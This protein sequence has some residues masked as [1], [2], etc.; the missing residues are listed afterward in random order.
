MKNYRPS[1]G[2]IFIGLFALLLGTGALLTA[3]GFNVFF[4]PRLNF[5]WLVAG[6][7][8]LCAI[9]LLTAALW[10][11]RNKDASVGA[12]GSVGGTATGSVSGSAAAFST[13]TPAAFPSTP[14]ASGGSG[15]ASSA[16]SSVSDLFDS[17]PA[18]ESFATSQTQQFSTQP[19]QSFATQPTQEFNS[20]TFGTSATDQERRFVPVSD[21][22]A[23]KGA[24]SSGGK[25]L[26]D[27]R[28]LEPTGEQVMVPLYAH[29]GSVDLLINAD[30]PVAIHLAMGT[31]SVTLDPALG[32]HRVGEEA[33]EEA[34]FVPAAGG[35]LLIGRTL[36][37]ADE[38]LLVVN[39]ESPSADLHIAAV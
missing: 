21:D 9:L 17:A 15:S 29:E 10:P 12:S 39:I 37:K 33:L 27:L 38:A 16:A 1:F 4:S 23:R 36:D 26:A 11:Q 20:A 34:A 2:T 22:D 32:L 5:T 7:L 24:S 18:T 25:V 28:W 3:F 31:G 8:I 14:T 6:L 30:S 35:E 19:T 13:T